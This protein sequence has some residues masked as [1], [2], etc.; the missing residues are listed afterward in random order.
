MFEV[1]D[2][3]FGVLEASIESDVSEPDWI[4]IQNLDPDTGG[5]KLPTKVEKLRNFMF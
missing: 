5:Q 3:L 2:D 1:L 4:R